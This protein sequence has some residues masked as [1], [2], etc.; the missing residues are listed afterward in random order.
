MPILHRRR[1][2]KEKGEVMEK[3]QGEAHINEYR[4]WVNLG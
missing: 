1:R 3:A 2:T 4:I